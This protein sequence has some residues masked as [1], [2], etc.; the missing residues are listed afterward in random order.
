MQAG[1]SNKM[2]LTN[3]PCSLLTLAQHLFW[4]AMLD[5][6]VQSCSNI[7]KGTLFLTI[8]KD[9]MVLFHVIREIYGECKD[10]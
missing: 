9:L 6:P 2:N 7:G 5:L 8:R 3:I 1:V 4:V 10:G